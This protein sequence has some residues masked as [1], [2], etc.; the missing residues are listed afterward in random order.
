MADA[1][2]A[3]R[4]RRI[5]SEAGQKSSDAHDCSSTRGRIMNAYM[6]ITGSGPIVV[7]TRDRKSTRR[8]PVTNAPLVCRLLLEKKKHRSF[9]DIDFVKTKAI[10]MH[11]SRSLEA[12]A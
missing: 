3:K 8:T 12:I 7:L 11:H 9:D 2:L 10:A 4:V 5:R 6:L 1:P